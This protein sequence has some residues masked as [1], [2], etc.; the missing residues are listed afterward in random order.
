MVEDEPIIVEPYN[1]VDVEAK[2]KDYIKK[3]GLAT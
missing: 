1:M 2:I 3:K